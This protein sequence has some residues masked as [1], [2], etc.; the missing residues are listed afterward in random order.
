MAAI[1][2]PGTGSHV[3]VYHKNGCVQCMMTMKQFDQMG[4]TYDEINIDNEPEYAEMLKQEG[5]MQAPVIK[6]D[7]G[8]TDAWTGFRL[9]KIRGLA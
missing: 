1:I 9:D 3:T 5:Y 2:T 7:N 4:V 6:I 8:A